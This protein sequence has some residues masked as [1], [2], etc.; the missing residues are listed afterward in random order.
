MPSKAD[1]IQTDEIETVW[2]DVSS[3][4]KALLETEAERAARVALDAARAALEGRRP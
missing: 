1:D 4:E 2:M 3:E